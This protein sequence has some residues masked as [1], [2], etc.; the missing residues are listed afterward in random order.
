MTTAAKIIEVEVKNLNGTTRIPALTLDIAW[1]IFEVEL[2]AAINTNTASD[3]RIV[4]YPRNKRTVNR[5]AF[6]KRL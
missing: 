5:E 4:S 1:G 3:I 6:T 2:A